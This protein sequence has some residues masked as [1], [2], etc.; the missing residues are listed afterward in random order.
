MG[1]FWCQKS[2]N[3][4]GSSGGGNPPPSGSDDMLAIVNAER[5]KRGLSQMRLDSRL[6]RAA[7]KHSDYQQSIGRMTHDGPAG[8]LQ[9]FYARIKAEG[10]ANP[11][12]AAENVAWG[13]R[14]VA[15]AMNS[16]MNSPGHFRNLMNPS[17][18]FLGWGRS[19][20]N[21]WTQVFSQSN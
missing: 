20:G 19:S 17:Y 12:A 10:I 2:C 16:W 21:Y 11:G 15:D 18:N 14:S 13:Q 7:Q 5:S 4:C 1:A 3:T 8:P 9:S 6:M